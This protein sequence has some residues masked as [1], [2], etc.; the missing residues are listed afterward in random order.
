[1]LIHEDDNHG[2]VVI[3]LQFG[4]DG[5]VKDHKLRAIHTLSPKAAIPVAEG[6]E[7]FSSERVLLM[8]DDSSNNSQV[9]AKS[10]N[11]F[12]FLWSAISKI[13]TQTLIDPLTFLRPIVYALNMCRSLYLLSSNTKTRQSFTSSFLLYALQLKNN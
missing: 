6:S 12:R 9:V 2:N 4:E 5:L 1:M 13:V 7:E 10:L 8:Q 11:I 3:L